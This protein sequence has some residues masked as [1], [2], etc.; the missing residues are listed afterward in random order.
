MHRVKTNW[1]SIGLSCPMYTSSP[2][3]NFPQW[4]PPL[5]SSTCLY[6]KNIALPRT[7]SNISIHGSLRTITLLCPDDGKEGAGCYV[8]VVIVQGDPLQ[9][10]VWAPTPHLYIYN[11]PTLWRSCSRNVTNLPVGPWPWIFPLYGFP[12]GFS[13]NTCWRLFQCRGIW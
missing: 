4:P 7:H 1:S 2:P 6:M 9:G 10:L 13:L 5:P 3:E 8:V 11:C 12:L